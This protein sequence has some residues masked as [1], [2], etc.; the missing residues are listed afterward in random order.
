MNDIFLKWLDDFM[1]V[2]I[3]D[4]LIYSNSME[5][6]VEHLRKVFQK[7]RENKLYAKFEKCEFGVTEVD[8]LRHKITQKGLKMDDHK[9]K[10]ILDWEPP[11]LVPALRSFL[12]LASYYYKFIKNFAKIA[13]P[14]TNVLKKSSRTY[15]WDEICDEAFETL[16]GILVKTIV[17]TYEIR[18]F[19]ESVQKEV[20]SNIFKKAL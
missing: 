17:V 1:V 15:D 10:A 8:F 9:V 16:K 18:V 20:F 19:F 7:L 14:L 2:Y 6:H 13:A 4:I 3:D 11:R 12:G 5:D